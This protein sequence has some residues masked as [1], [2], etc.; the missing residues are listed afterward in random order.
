[1]YATGPKV[2]AIVMSAALLVAGC[3][4]SSNEAAP[5]G[6]AEASGSAGAS[7][8]PTQIT[9]G[10]DKANDHGSKTVSGESSVEV[11]QDDFYFGPTILTGDPGQQLTI[12]LHNEGSVTHNFSIDA[13]SVDTT[14]N[15]GSEASVTVTFPNSGFVEFYCKFHRA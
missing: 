10:S 9:I 15:A 1:M 13:Q 2:G 3:S 8:S 14:V 6:S 11:E 7:A 12:M 5:S 4:K